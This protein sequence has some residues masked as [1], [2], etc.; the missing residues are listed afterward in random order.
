VQSVSAKQT[1]VHWLDAASQK[2][3]WQSPL[4]AQLLPSV[5]VPGEA[6]QTVTTADIAIA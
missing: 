1:S 4:L 2:P 6:E 3:L 5:A